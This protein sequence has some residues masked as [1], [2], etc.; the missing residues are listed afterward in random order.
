MLRLLLLHLTLVYEVISQGLPLEL[1]FELHNVQLEQGASLKEG[2]AG[3]KTLNVNTC[4]PL[5]CWKRDSRVNLEIE[6][7]EL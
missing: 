7:Y 4:D 2:A 1:I 3:V 5:E 6:Q